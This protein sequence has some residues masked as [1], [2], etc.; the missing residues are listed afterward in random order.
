VPGLG[1]AREAALLE[2]FGS[3]Q[4]VAAARPDELTKVRGIGPG[5]AARIVDSLGTGSY[6]GRTS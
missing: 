5:L 3:L 2:A 1:A 4:A 6:A